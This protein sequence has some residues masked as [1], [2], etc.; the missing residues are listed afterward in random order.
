MSAVQLSLL[1]DSRRYELSGYGPNRTTNAKLRES[2]PHP[3]VQIQKI[4]NCILRVQ[5]ACAEG[6]GS[7]SKRTTSGVR[8]C[9]L[10]CGLR[11][12]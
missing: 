3:F 1:G 6:R 4:F 12:M 11:M 10:E 5:A 8:A 2:W 9:R 7:K